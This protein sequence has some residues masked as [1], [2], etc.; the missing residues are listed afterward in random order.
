MNWNDT[1]KSAD[2]G[3]RAA[4]V[5]MIALIPEDAAQSAAFLRLVH[6]EGSILGDI[7]VDQRYTC[8]L[9]PDQRRQLAAWLTYEAEDL[10]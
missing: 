10:T 2:A 9:T 1:T 7:V 8:L 6:H 5:F 4:D 3:S